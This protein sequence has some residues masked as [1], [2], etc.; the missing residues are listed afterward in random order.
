M[1]ISH[2][3]GIGL[4]E[5]EARGKGNEFPVFDRCP[6]CHCVSQGNLHRNG[7]Y[8]RYGIDEADQ[9]LCIPICQLRCLAC[10]VN[11]SIL[12]DFLIP[13]FQHT[14]YAMIERID[15][16]SLGK[17]ERLELSKHLAQHVMRFYENLHWIHTFFIDSGLQSGLSQNLKKEALKYMKRLQN[18]GVSTF[19]RR[20]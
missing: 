14:L 16:F 8:W 12:P 2:D 15:Y 10:G 18:I 17:R 6:S 9:A 13:Y 4:I 11:I 3:F 5:Y 20:S 1:I 7:F 19:F